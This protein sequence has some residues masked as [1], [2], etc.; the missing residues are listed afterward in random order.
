MCTYNE[1]HTKYNLLSRM[2]KSKDLEINQ[3]ILWIEIQIFT[4]ESVK[5]SLQTGGQ[6]V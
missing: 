1:V 2:H 4:F 3:S 6:L 5:Y